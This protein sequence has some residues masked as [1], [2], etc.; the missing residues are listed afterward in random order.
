MCGKLGNSGQKSG[1]K[2]CGLFDKK[3]VAVQRA[4]KTTSGAAVASYI[5]KYFFVII[6][7]LFSVFIVDERSKHLFIHMNLC[8]LHTIIVCYPFALLNNFS[9]VSIPIFLK[10]FSI[11]SGIPIGIFN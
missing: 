1:Q 4:R 10:P 2:S 3:K 9:K 5:A 11:F 7:L 6:F 8:I